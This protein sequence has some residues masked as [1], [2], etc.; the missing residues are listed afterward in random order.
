LPASLTISLHPCLGD[1]PGA[2]QYTHLGMTSHY[3]VFEDMFTGY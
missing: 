3:K 1:V 2:L